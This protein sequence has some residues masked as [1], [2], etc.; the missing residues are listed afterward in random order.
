MTPWG[1]DFGGFSVA[2]EVVAVLAVI[3]GGAL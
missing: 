2:V 3:G 1:V